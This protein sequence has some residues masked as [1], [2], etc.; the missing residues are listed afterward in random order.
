MLCIWVFKKFDTK[1]M[2][3]AAPSFCY[4][5]WVILQ[6]QSS[7]KYKYINITKAIKFKLLQKKLRATER[8]RWLQHMHIRKLN[9]VIM[10]ANI[11]GKGPNS[12]WQ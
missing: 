5:Y 3:A 2:N 11:T 6:D 10:K 7:V 8:E 12:E 9:S 4:I 1:G